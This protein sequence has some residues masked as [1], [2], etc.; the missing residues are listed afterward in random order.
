MQ[1]TALELFFLSAAPA[2]FDFFTT[3]GRNEAYKHLK[4]VSSVVSA[5]SHR[6]SVEGV[7]LE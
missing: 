2:L 1:R 7:W 4:S 3:A 5:S 6:M